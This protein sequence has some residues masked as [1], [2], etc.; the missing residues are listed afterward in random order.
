MREWINTGTLRPNI[1]LDTYVVMPNHFHGI[2]VIN[3]CADTIQRRGVSQYAPTN[4]FRSPSQTVGAII[5]GFKSAVSKQINHLR[6]KPGQSVW[7]RNYYEHI[8][9]N[10]KELNSIREYIIN[11]P[12]QWD[13]DENN[14]KNI[15]SLL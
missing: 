2:L 13:L 5:R 6:D 15:K 11:N 7:Q 1:E 9:R 4:A 3:D 10:E 12:M 14:P 8:V